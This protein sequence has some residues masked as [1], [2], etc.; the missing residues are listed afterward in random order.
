MALHDMGLR[1]DQVGIIIDCRDSWWMLVKTG[2]AVRNYREA[3]ES[4]YF[5]GHLGYVARYKGKWAA[6]R[7]AKFDD[8]LGFH[9][10]VSTGPLGRRTSYT[11]PT[12]WQAAE[13][14]WDLHRSDNM[15]AKGKAQLPDVMG[16]YRLFAV[17]DDGGA[18][19]ESCVRDHDNPVHDERDKHTVD[20][21]GWGVVAFATS[22][23][24]DEDTWC[25]HCNAYIGPGSEPGEAA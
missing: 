5:G 10:A 12:R 6:Y 9:H 11:Y 13:Y 21:D 8:R 24:I 15:F 16:G 14:L 2:Y 7:P 20:S 17:M 19:C 23:E 25:D 4:G 22:G 18:L 3:G 1:F